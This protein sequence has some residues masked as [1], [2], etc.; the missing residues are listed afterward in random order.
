MGPSYLKTLLRQVLLRLDSSVTKRN[1][2]EEARLWQTPTLFVISVILT[3][4][5]LVIMEEE[6]IS[7]TTPFLTYL[8][9]NSKITSL[10]KEQF[11]CFWG[12]K[13]LNLLSKILL[14]MIISLIL[15]E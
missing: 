6:F 7:N 13:I 8:T 11:L 12:T 5:Q 2:E 15:Q 10:I 14:S 4:I 1:M 9:Q 3:E